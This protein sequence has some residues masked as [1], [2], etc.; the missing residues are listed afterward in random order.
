MPKRI[1]IW[2]GPTGV[3]AGWR[4]LFYFVLLLAFVVCGEAVTRAIFHGR[5]PDMNSP[6]V[7]AIDLAAYAAAV[8]LAGAGMAQIERRSLTEY[9]FPLRRAFGA[10]FWQGFA[11][12]LASLV[13]LLGALRLIGVYSFG[14][15]ELHGTDALRYGA[16]WAAMVFLGA[17]VEEFLYRGY[18]QYTLSGAIGFWPAAFATSALMAA[19]HLFNPG[20]TWLGIATVAGFGLVACLLLQRSGDLWLPLGLHAAWNFGEAF[21]FGIPCS[22]Q[23]GEGAL[24]HGSFHGPTWITGMPFGVE[25][26]WPN[27]VLMILWWFAFSKWLPNVNYPPRTVARETAA[28]LV[29]SELV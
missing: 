24:R 15:I 7:N 6:Y 4:I 27:V 21:L 23:M 28:S 3:R 29:E 25:A 8:L 14:A 5:Q 26:G 1:S 10:R 19:L 18:L 17:V 2:R 16:V 9:G 12:G 20:W 11:I 22:G 13:F